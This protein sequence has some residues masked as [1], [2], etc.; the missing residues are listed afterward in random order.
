VE[1]VAKSIHCAEPNFY[2]ELGEAKRLLFCL[3][4]SEPAALRA[5]QLL[6]IHCRHLLLGVTGP[7]HVLGRERRVELRQLFGA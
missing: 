7:G 4:G 1:E 6:A 3:V 2:N 5:E